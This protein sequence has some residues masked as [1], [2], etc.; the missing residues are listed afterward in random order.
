MPQ[1]LTLFATMFPSLPASTIVDALGKTG[2]DIQLTAEALLETS[3]VVLATKPPAKNLT[4]VT[5]DF[6]LYNDGP[7]P[8]PKGAAKPAVEAAKKT[9]AVNANLSSLTTSVR[10]EPPQHTRTQYQP[11][12]KVRGNREIDG[13]QGWMFHVG[14]FVFELVA[15]KQRLS[16]LHA[17]IDIALKRDKADYTDGPTLNAPRAL[18][19]AISLGDLA[20]LEPDK[21]ELL[22][23][24][25]KLNEIATT[26]YF[27]GTKFVH[28][29]P[30]QPKLRVA[31]SQESAFVRFDMYFGDGSDEDSIFG[32]AADYDV[33]TVMN[34]ITPAGPIKK[35]PPPPQIY[36][37]TPAALA[38]RRAKPGWEFTLAGTRSCLTTA[39]TPTAAAA[40]AAAASPSRLPPILRRVLARSHQRHTQACVCA[41]VRAQVLCE[42]WKI[43][44]ILRHSSRPGCALPCASSSSRH[45]VGCSRKSANQTG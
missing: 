4:S 38:E 25:D 3:S 24:L 42:K 29:E 18:L 9:E 1:A 2:G 13:F 41:C 31:A 30:A 17:D 21:M 19:T 12:N 27:K 20:P 40:A 26:G 6:P 5:A 39:P 14:Y 45:W 22:R 33:W 8:R 23:S 37:G 34:Q 28:V 10:L 36:A 35:P 7:R 44:A 43:R 16:Q 32:L 11:P 15:N